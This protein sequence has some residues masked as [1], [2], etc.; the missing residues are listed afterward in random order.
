MAS[1]ADVLD[2]V[3]G[4]YRAWSTGDCALWTSLWAGDG[5]FHDP[6]GSSGKV[7]AGREQ[8]ASYFDEVMAL[9]SLAYTRHD[10]WQCGNEVAVVVAC[11]LRR[12]DGST[13]I[14]DLVHTFEVTADGK[15]WR[16][17]TFTDDEHQRVV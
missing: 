10:M 1:P 16:V 6:T 7:H 15:L 2:A 17:R 13:K 8:L 12:H 14:K 5:E 9:M 3:E 4:Y 11:E